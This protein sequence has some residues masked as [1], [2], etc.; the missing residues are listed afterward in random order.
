MTETTPNPSSENE[1]ELDSQEIK[2]IW[3]RF[4][5]FVFELLD[6][7]HG[8]DPKATIEGI[9]KDIPFKGHTA[10]ILVFSIFI[11]SI[12]LNTNSAAVV[13][14]AMLISPLMGPIL[15]I[16]LS[17]G[18]NDIDTLRRS[19]LNFGVMVSLSI[20][21]AFIYFKVSPFQI[22]SNEILARTEPTVL[23]VLIAIFGGLAGIMAG[24]R[25]EKSNAIPGVAIA[26]ALMP[27]L[28]TAGFGLATGNYPF[29]FGALYLF[30]INTV[31]I[32][33]ST[34]VVVKYLRFPLA[35]Y[36]TAKK[37]KRVNRMVALVAL[38]VVIP[39]VWSFVKIINRTLYE[40]EATVFINDY[41]KFEGAENV[42]SKIDSEN[43]RIE[44]YFVG[45]NVPDQVISIWKS[46]IEKR[47]RLSGSE[48]NIKQGQDKIAELKAEMS[49]VKEGLIKDLFLQ[50]NQSQI[51]ND[52]ETQ[53]TILK[54]EIKKLKE[55]RESEAIPLTKI[56]AEAKINYPSI[57]SMS[58]AKVITTDL[59]KTDT[60][61]V[62]EV[63]WDTKLRR[64]DKLKQR[65]KLKK[66]LKYKLK[67][68]TLLVK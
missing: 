41:L 11:A 3:R 57:K 23:D 63:F 48:L 50:S 16:G 15:G 59:K 53:I 45:D 24:S 34:F 2:D 40:N 10:W 12:G 21:T 62:F 43:R 56:A 14:G 6:I 55:R 35:K 33:L 22:A 29:F 5:Q 42:K 46:E 66:W 28:C 58:Y 18:I 68:D 37:R 47:N 65:A 64:S 39:S 60:I 25:K 54:N 36:A 52:K 13:I 19:L 30:G 44:V 31:F 26:T 67:L 20:L 51:E 4:K 9:K 27:P 32:A 17:V 61:P 38:I 49:K 8:A 7:R 1:H